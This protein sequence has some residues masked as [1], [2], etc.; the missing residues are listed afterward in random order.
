MRKLIVALLASAAGVMLFA[1]FVVAQGDDEPQ[2][3]AARLGLTPQGVLPMV[4][5]DSA[6]GENTA[7]EGVS[8]PAGTAS[9]SPSSTVTATKTGS[10]TPTGTATNTPTR[11]PTVGPGTPTPTRTST[12]TS[13]ST[14]TATGTATLT[15]TSTVTTTA[16]VTSTTT[17][18]STS[19]ATVTSTATATA[20]ATSTATTPVIVSLS[21]S[22]VVEGTRTIQING[23]G[24]VSG[25]TVQ[26]RNI[27]EG[28]GS[29][30]NVSN[31]VF[32][33]SGLIQITYNFTFWSHPYTVAETQFEVKVVGSNGTSN[34]S[35]LTVTQPAP[36]VCAGPT[37]SN[38]GG[39]PF[40][41]IQV[42]HG[43]P[44]TND[45]V[46]V[47]VTMGAGVSVDAM[48]F[49]FAN[50]T[51]TTTRHA[52]S[53]VGTDPSGNEIWEAT[54]TYTGTPTVNFGYRIVADVGGSTPAMIEPTTAGTSPFGSGCEYP[55]GAP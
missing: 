18:T 3:A 33:H 40:G 35:V 21:P 27:T 49:R 12:P 34:G 51:C 6:L 30:E 52:F 38:G 7:V 55:P 31:V 50:G 5:A 42:S 45:S 9:P 10:P 48:Y 53:M 24:F 46:T 44:C 22:S 36:P 41:A 2:S 16:T 32:Q 54:A 17:A 14:G 39:S 11:T 43:R 28:P 20:T 37:S 1:T 26:V 4:A 15:A 13:T 19:T 47:R 29:P 8:P 25:S 23:S